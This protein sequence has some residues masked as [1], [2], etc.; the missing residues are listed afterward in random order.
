MT[1]TA[2]Q[3]V[4]DLL[5]QQH[6]RIRELLA[7]VQ[8]GQ[9]AAKRDAF[10]DLVRLLAVH[11][12]AEEQVVHP[13]ARKAGADGA[14][15]IVQ[16]RLNEEH[17][18]K[19]V[20]ARLYDMGVDHPDFDGQFGTFA[21]AVAAHAAHEEVDEF[22]RLRE[23]VPPERLRRMAG[24]VKMAESMA[25]TRPH[26]AAGESPAGNM[27]VGPPMAIFDRARDQMRDWRESNPD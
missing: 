1:T 27:L 3:D 4:V 25:P 16:E 13:R 18:A 17:E 12:S 2:Q 15:R 6:N 14:D 8:G 19:Q 23:A 9:G 7:A 26:P 24:A 10:E 21:E 5:L 20:L 11:E 22:P